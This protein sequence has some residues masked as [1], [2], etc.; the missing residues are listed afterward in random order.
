MGSTRRPLHCAGVAGVAQWF[1]VK[2]E[3]VTK[4]MLRHPGYPEPDVTISPGRNG[5]PDQ[6]WLPEREAE[7]REWKASLPGQ[8]AGG[9]RPRKPAEEGPQ[10]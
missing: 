8:G 1:G 4:W 7:W 10:P 6:G 2:P 5:R 3:T 9:G